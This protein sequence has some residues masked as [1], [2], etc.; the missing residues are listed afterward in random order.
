[1]GRRSS[2]L[3]GFGTG[4]TLKGVGRPGDI[5]WSRVFVESGMMHIDM[6]L[7]K[8]V[9]LPADETES[10]WKEVT[11]QWPM[12][13]VVMEG[14]GRDAFMARHRANH[15][16]IAYASNRDEAMH[17]LQVKAAM[18]AALGIRVN[19]CGVVL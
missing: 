14:V 5:V 2:P 4:G 15:V 13:S 18:C 10:R 7:A 19:L 3:T 9:T 6:G 11:R 8:V 16:S 12:V 17:A 1:M